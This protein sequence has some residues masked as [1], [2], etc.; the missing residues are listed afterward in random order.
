[1]KK[2]GILGGTFDP[3][4]NAHY[5]IA[6]RALEQYNLEKVVFIPSGTPWQKDTKTS[7]EDRYKMTNLLIQYNNFFELSDIEKS[8][9]NPSY[10]F[11]TLKKL[12]HPK[13]GL[14]FILGSD[15]AMNIKTWKNYKQ[16]SDLTNFLIALRREDKPEMLNENFPFDYELIHGEKLD[17]SSSAIRKEL[18]EMEFLEKFGTFEEDIDLSDE[19]I[20]YIIENDLYPEN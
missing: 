20:D 2:T 3:P 6:E 17:L 11:E 4:H 16:L 7:F 13:E 15:I 8:E 9:E 19:I 18:E 10:T 12:G 1:M 5:E 14:Y